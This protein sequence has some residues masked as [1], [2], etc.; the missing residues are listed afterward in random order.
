MT[1]LGCPRKGQAY[2]IPSETLNLVGK[3]MAMALDGRDVSKMIFW[4]NGPEISL[5]I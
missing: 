1:E 2:T 4:Q 3:D 5:V